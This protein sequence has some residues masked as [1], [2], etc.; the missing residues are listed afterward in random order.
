MMSNACRGEKNFNGEL[1]P[2]SWLSAHM[3]QFRDASGG[4][5]LGNEDIAVFIETSIVRMDEL[6]GRPAVGLASDLE[7]VEN[8]FGPLR[9]ITQ[10]IDHFIFFV[11]Q[12]D[13]GMEVGHQQ[14][15]T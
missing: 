2:R 12:A 14:H 10:V 4:D 11:E 1:T 13:T 7:A 5:P 6:A 3:S 8:L 9:V 15:F